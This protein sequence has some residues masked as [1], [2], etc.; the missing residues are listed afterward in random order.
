MN[1][2]FQY[3]D[4]NERES[5]INNNLDK[6]LIE[7]QNIEEGNFLIFSSNK[8]LSVEVAELKEKQVLSNQLVADNSLAQQELLELLIDMGVI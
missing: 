3:N 1:Y 6:F 2:K 8:P 5:A 7:E 4:L